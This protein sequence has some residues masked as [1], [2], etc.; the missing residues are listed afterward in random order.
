M[1]RALVT[2]AII[3]L[4]CIAPPALAQYDEVP[5]EWLV[6]GEIIIKPVLTSSVDNIVDRLEDIVGQGLVQVLRSEDQL[7]Y[8]TIGIPILPPTDEAIEM[9][10]IF[11]Q[12]IEDGELSWAEPNLVV[13]DVGGQTGSLWVSGIGIDAGGY[14]NQYATDILELDQAHQRSTGRGVLVAY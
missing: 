12:A 3:G 2:P 7:G 6:P 9:R 10:E 5:P 8:Y 13:D 1:K 4:A 14:A 11:D